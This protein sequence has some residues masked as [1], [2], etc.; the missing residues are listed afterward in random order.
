MWSNDQFGINLMIHFLKLNA[1]SFREFFCII[2]ASCVCEIFLLSWCYIVC[3][4]DK[5]FYT[6]YAKNIQDIRND[7]VMNLKENITAWNFPWK[8]WMTGGKDLERKF[9]NRL[10]INKRL[11]K[12]IVLLLKKKKK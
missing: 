4:C 6:L 8:Y 3:L 1:I 9:Q 12:E 10:K 2:M 11:F 5:N 7:I